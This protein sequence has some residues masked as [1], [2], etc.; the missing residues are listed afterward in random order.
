MARVVEHDLQEKQGKH[1]EGHGNGAIWEEEEMF[2]DRQSKKRKWKRRINNRKRPKFQVPVE[3]EEEGAV[4][5][6]DPLEVFGRDLMMMILGN[7]DARSIALSLLVSHGWHDVASSDRLWSS[8][9]PFLT[10]ALNNF[11]SLILMSPVCD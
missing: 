4:R 6:K 1:I 7:L 5:V 10:S 8:K 11:F 9:V 3:E 2:V